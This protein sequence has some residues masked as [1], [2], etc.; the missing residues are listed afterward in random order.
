ME[1]A[2]LER[3]LVEHTDA[4]NSHDIDRLMGLFADECVFEASAGPKCHGHR[5]DGRTQVRGRP[6]VWCR[7]VRVHH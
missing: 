3:R 2:D 4:W 5:F 7:W 1:R 6:R